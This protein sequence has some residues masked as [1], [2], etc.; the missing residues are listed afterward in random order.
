VVGESHGPRLA[1]MAG[2]HVN[3]VSGIAATVRLVETLASS[4]LCGSV[5]LIGV[6]NLPALP[7]R[8]VLTCPVD[9]R[10]INGCFPGDPEGTFSPA[11]A[12]AV[13]NEWADDA[14]C[15][16]DLHGADLCEEIVRYAVCQ[17]T[18]DDA[19]D[20]A[21]LAL[22]GLFDV[23]LVLSLRAEYRERPGRSVTGRAAAGR[24]GAFAEAGAGGVVDDDSVAFHHDGVV[25]I[26]ERHGMLPAGSAPP[27]PD[28]AALPVLHDY[29]TFAS[30]T[31]GWCRIRVAPGQLVSEGETIAE[32][33]PLGSDECLE[34]SAPAAGTI[35]WRDTNPI[36]S[37]GRE[38][39]GLGY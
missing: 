35:L 31:T 38:I 24:H 5:S 19:F 8:E 22:A 2:M 21:A 6:L 28:R 7:S 3:E 9:G 20:A 12:H 36:V 15:L 13:L 4:D 10:N 29:A 25:R 17:T 23:Q 32:L 27:L 30:P 33:T 39:G 18:G 26:A 1:V 11:L 14:D 16:V 37:E 34:V